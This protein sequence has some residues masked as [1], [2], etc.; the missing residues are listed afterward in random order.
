M[1]K[2]LRYWNKNKRKILITIAVIA[3]VIIII[4]IANKIAEEQNQFN[5]TG[6]ELNTQ[7]SQDITKPNESI[8]SETILSET[9]TESNSN[10]IKQ[11]VEYCNKKDIEKAYEMLSEDCK[12]ELYSTSSI[13]KENYIDLIF[14]LEKSYGLEL[15]YQNNGHY[16]YQITY[17]EGNL[18]ATGGAISSKNFIDYITIIREDNQL[19]LN[20]NNFIAKENI[21]KQAEKDGIEVIVNSK[22]IYL[23]YEIYN[24][25]VKNNTEKTILLSDKK[26]LDSICLVDEND[27]KYNSVISEVPTS[28]LTLNSKYRKTMDIKFNKPYVTNNEILY[29]QIENIYLDQSQYDSND[30]LENIEKTNIQIQL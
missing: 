22:S 8:I 26:N 10:F 16:T 9:E 20:I 21:N 5:D 1:E 7:I 24:I 18:L 13:F 15:W 3:L 17:N 27:L 14:F 4:Q 28:S 6:Q 12:S 30:A 2:L 25:T 23:D 11:F 29:M 19:K